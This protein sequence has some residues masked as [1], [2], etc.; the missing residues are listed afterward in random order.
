MARE[1]ADHA[2]RTFFRLGV[3]RI[4]EECNSLAAQD[5][6]EWS[7]RDP[8]STMTDLGLP[9]TTYRDGIQELAIPFELFEPASISLDLVDTVY[10]PAPSCPAITVSLPDPRFSAI[11]VFLPTLSFEGPLI[12]WRRDTFEC[13]IYHELLHACGDTEERRGIKDG[14][15]RHTLV[16]CGAVE[17]LRA[18]EGTSF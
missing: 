11:T 14:V 4:Q 6:A 13:V 8:E 17:R 1:T 7:L 9:N 18:R 10:S 3:R 2:F 15:I 16:G 5:R 12:R